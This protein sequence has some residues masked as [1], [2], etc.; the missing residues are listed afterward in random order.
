MDASV[1]EQPVAVNPNGQSHAGMASAPRVEQPDSEVMI[2]VRDVGKMYRL[3][4]RPQDRLKQ[5]L[6]WRFNKYYGREFWA[7]RDISFEVRKGESVGIIGRNGS[8][9]STLLQIIAGTLS[10][11]TGELQVKGRVAA[12]LELGSGFNPEFT[13]RENVFLNGAVL[14]IS[15]EEMEQ[16]YDEIVTFADIG[17]FI[18]QPVKLYSSGM[19][20]RLAFAVQ[21]VV[22][23]DVLIVDEALAVGDEAF[24][25]KCMR[26]LEDFR[27]NGG[28]V[29]LVSHNAQMII[30]QCDRCIFLHGGQIILDGSSKPVTDVYQSF[31]YGTPQQQSEILSIARHDRHR[32]DEIATQLAH[33]LAGATEGMVPD[34]RSDLSESFDMTMPQTTEIAYGNGAAEILDCSMHDSAGR[35]VNLLIAGQRYLWRYRVRFHETSH[36]LNFGMMLRSVEGIAVLAINSEGEGYHYNRFQRGE[37]VE[38]RFGVQIDLAPRTYYVESGVVGDSET[39]TGEGGFLHRRL[40]ICAVRVVAPDTRPIY[41]LVY[42]HPIVQVSTVQ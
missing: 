34:V 21:A 10:P 8:G 31:L 18:D 30:R 22:Q 37:V 7:L 25:R 33:K 36:N 14:G 35:R 32:P 26:K 15:R 28:T 5:Q 11:T 6:F 17:E 24:Q 39:P 9:K 23:K 42:S 1:I 40:D 20:V 13:G 4:D 38:V 16:R 41:G 2:S 27:A 3:Y 12:L 19:V 29:L